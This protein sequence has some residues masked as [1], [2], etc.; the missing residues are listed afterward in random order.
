MHNVGQDVD[1]HAH[2]Q[3]EQERSF[4]VVRVKCI[5]LDSMKSVIF[6]QVEI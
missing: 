2:K 6:Y 1:L 5:N 4:D 3:N